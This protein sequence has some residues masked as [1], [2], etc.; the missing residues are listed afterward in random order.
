MAESSATLHEV[1]RAGGP[2]RARRGIVVAVAAV[3]L[4]VV[5]YYGGGALWVHT[6]DD[7]TDFAAES[8]APEGGSRAIALAADLVEREVDRHRWVANDPFFL[9]GSVLDNMPNYQQGTVTAV[10]RFALEMTDQLGRTRGSSQADPDL[11][12]AAGLL[13]YPGTVWLFDFSTSLAPTA[14]SESQYRRAVQALRAYNE[15]LARGE[16][17]FEPRSDNL[18]ATL[19]R[20][21]ADL[22]S[23]SAA[24][25]QRI[26][27]RPFLVDTQADDLF[28]RT[29]GRLYGYHLLLRELGHD[30]AAVIRERQLQAAWAQMLASFR[31]AATLDPLVVTNGAP[32]GQMLPNHLAAQGFYLLRA[33]TQLKEIG[34]ILLK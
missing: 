21:A 20:M 23:A 1:E 33:R 28:Y 24:L 27:E 30:F 25:D 18:M 8:T 14:S 5:L 6:I 15:R 11:E 7:D 12:R 4:L 16:A 9:P 3:A 22:G 10:S 2:G 34:N 29:R 32:D 19:E 31:D 17:V 13:R 26:A